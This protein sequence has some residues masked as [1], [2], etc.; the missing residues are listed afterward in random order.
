MKLLIRPKPYIDESLESYLLRL[1]LAN[2]YDS[3]GILVAAM[4]NSFPQLQRLAGSLPTDLNSINVYHANH[5]SAKRYRALMELVELTGAD[6]SKIESLIVFRSSQSFSKQYQAVIYQG[7]IIPRLF[8]RENTLPICPNCLEEA[9]YIRQLWH[10]KTYHVCHVHK[11]RLIKKCPEC[12]VN[13]N[14]RSAFSTT[15]CSCGFDLRESVASDIEDNDLLNCAN[16]LVGTTITAPKVLKD[17][18]ITQS[19]GCLLWW[20]L[21]K[22]EDKSK[23]IDEVNLTGFYEYLNNWPQSL[24]SD[25]T[26]RAETGNLTAV[27]DSKNRKFKEQYGQLL[28]NAARLPERS[29]SANFILYEIISWFRT[30]LTSPSAQQF[31]A[32]QIDFIETAILLN[33]TTTEVYR[34][35]EEGYLKTHCRTKVGE[36]IS[37]SNTVFSLGDVF[38][39]WISGFQT[40]HSNLQHFLSKW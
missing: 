7:K 4:M 35:M 5:S 10:F 6:I 39:L 28:L 34:L 3:F 26:Q 21:E 37:L 11:K 9:P 29:L 23:S 25:L 19:F 40:E 24:L 16:L 17:K 38:D 36:P 27:T 32:L 8:L 1:C 22:C 14:Y 18:T 12:G 31:Q 15:T 13:I 2:Y 20:W 30:Q 33:T